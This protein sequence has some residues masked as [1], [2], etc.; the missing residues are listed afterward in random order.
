M[1]A[2]AAIFVSRLEKDFLPP[3]NE[4]TI[5]LNVVLP[6]GTSLAASN[7]I[8]RIGRGIA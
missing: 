7:T 4:G 2:I 1:V 5:Q 8:A 3:F 6:P